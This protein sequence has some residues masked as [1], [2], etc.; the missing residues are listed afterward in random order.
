VKHVLAAILVLALAACS[1]TRPPTA[2]SPAVTVT[3]TAPVRSSIVNCTTCQQEPRMWA[4]A[5]FPVTLSNGSAADRVLV[6]LTTRVVNRTRGGEIASNVRPNADH[7]YPST[8]IAPGGTLTVEGGVIYFP[9]PPPRDDV[10][11]EVIA[12]FDDGSSVTASGT[13]VAAG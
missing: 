2:P 7:P 6:T 13:I 10:V 4:A 12:R 5:E 11:V 9:L 3:F 1:D 8:R